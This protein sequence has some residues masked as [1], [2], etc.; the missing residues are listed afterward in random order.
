MY[1]T[2][3]RLA[4]PTDVIGAVLTKLRIAAMRFE[5]SANISSWMFAECFVP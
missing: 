5:L 4:E 2:G 3:V 1:T